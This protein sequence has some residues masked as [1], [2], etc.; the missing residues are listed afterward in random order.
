[1]GTA[2]DERGKGPGQ[3]SNRSRDVV[4]STVDHPAHYKSPAHCRECLRS[5]EC[6]DVVE[7]MGFSLGNVI[8]Y[9]WR[10]QAKGG[11]EDLRK[12]AWYLQ[13]EIERWEGK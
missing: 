7:H 13:H 9:V 12:A 1:M 10:A 8:K 3:P 2:R 6:I 11:I 4:P 5:I